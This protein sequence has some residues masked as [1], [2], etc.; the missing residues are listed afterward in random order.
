LEVT[1]RCILGTVGEIVLIRML[2][3]VSMV[4]LFST[5]MILDDQNIVWRWYVC[6]GGAQSLVRTGE[7]GG[8]GSALN[9]DENVA[10]AKAG[11]Q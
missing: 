6:E 7:L 2:S 11:R 10:L 5:A 9:Q 4:G 3:E 8:T 1:V